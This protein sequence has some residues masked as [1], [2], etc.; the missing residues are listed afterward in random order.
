MG[1]DD[2]I[3]EEAAALW[4]QLYGEAPPSG[5]RGSD[6]LGLIVGGLPDTDYNRIQTPHLR[7]NTIT[8]PK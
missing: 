8:F 2:R 4:R 7:P 6:L 1:R 3:D 5:A